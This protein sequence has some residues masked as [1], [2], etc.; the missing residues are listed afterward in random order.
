ME[1]KDRPIAMFCT[2]GVRCEKSTAYLKDLGFKN[3]YQ[4]KGGILH[5]LQT[6][7]EEKSLWQGGCFVFDERIS[8][9][10]KDCQ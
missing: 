2:G 9:D 5:Y 7:P 10:Q 4:L 1:F 8:V 6:T 3:V